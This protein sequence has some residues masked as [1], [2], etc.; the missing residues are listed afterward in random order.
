MRVKLE[1]DGTVF[2]YEYKPM[3]RTRFRA[4]CRLAHSLIYAAVFLGSLLIVGT[5]ALVAAGILVF[6]YGAC[7]CIESV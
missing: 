3:E 2:E 1:R 5:P 4:L 6:L 7:R